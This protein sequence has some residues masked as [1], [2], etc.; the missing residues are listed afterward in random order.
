MGCS[1]STTSSNNNFKY[2][3]AVYGYEYPNFGFNKIVNLT[4]KKGNKLYLLLIYNP[5]KFLEMP[6]EMLPENLILSY[7]KKNLEKSKKKDYEITKKEK[8]ES[9]STVMESIIEKATAKNV[10]LLVVGAVGHKGIK[11]SNNLKKGL[12]YLISNIVKFLLRL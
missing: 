11:K 6:S 5:K 4:L 7:E 12:H 8:P 3:I 9:Q 1:W 2:C 10:N